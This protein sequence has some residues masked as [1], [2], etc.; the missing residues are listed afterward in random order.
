MD[1]FLSSHF[2]SESPEYYPE[3]FQGAAPGDGVIYI[4]SDDDMECASSASVDDLESLS[5]D[6]EVALLAQ[7]VERQMELPS[8]SES[9]PIPSTASK[10]EV[11]RAA[12]PR[13][14]YIPGPMFDAGYFDLGMGRGPIARDSRLRNDHPINLCSQLIPMVDTPMS[15]PA[16][17]K[18]PSGDWRIAAEAT[19][20]NSQ[21]HSNGIHFRGPNGGDNPYISGCTDCLVC[22]KSEEQI[23][24]EAVIDYLHKTAIRGESAEQ[25]NARRLALLERL[26]VGCFML[27]PGGVSQ[28]SACDGN[29]YSICHNYKKVQPYTLPLK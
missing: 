5:D 3:D 22:G 16:R 8:T 29:V 26:R 14:P 6:D 28:A 21:Q 12:T 1:K 19:T 20:S 4:S 10:Q 11:A 18:Y 24:D 7:C 27:I 13:L 9:I 25:F 17:D 2:D 23:Q 15:P